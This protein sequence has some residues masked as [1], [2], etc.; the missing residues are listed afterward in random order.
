MNFTP[1]EMPFYGGIAGMA[2]VTVVAIIVI[3]LLSG[4]RR[5]LR[6]KLGEEYGSVEKK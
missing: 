3:I 5:R 2:L 4:S 1:G 6:R